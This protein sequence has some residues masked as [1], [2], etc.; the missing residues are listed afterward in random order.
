MMRCLH[1][2]NS[3]QLSLADCGSVGIRVQVN[4]KETTISSGKWRWHRH[5]KREGPPKVT[6]VCHCV[7]DADL[8]GQSGMVLMRRSLL[9]T[10]DD[11]D[12]IGTSR[13]CDP[14]VLAQLGF[15]YIYDNTDAADDD[16]DE[17]EDDTHEV[18]GG[19][20]WS[21]VVPTRTVHTTQ[22]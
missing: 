8:R 6:C 14:L 20:G 17:V 21:R 9:R 1:L 2:G 15:Q 19:R 5:S 4:A 10:G 7:P 3:N 18:E 12:T 22:F 11:V 13:S 16:V